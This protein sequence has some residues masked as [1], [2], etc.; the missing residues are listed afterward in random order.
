MKLLPSS[1]TGF[2]LVLAALSSANPG[3]QCID[4]TIEVPVVARNAVF[5]LTAP[6]NNIEVTNY[7]LEQTRQGHD[8]TNEVL[9]GVC[10]IIAD[11]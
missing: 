4:M 2:I 1:S 8:F 9:T 10:T 3:R 5:N 7:V 11:P 6:K